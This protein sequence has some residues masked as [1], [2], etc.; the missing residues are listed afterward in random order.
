MELRFLKDEARAKQ[1]STNAKNGFMEHKRS[2]NKSNIHL[3]AGLTRFCH[4]DHGWKEIFPL[5]MDLFYR[6]HDA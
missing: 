4:N 1:G 2:Y 3:A 5:M 6:E